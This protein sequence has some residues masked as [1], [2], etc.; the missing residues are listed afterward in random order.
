LT[1]PARAAELLALDPMMRVFVSGCYDIV[2]AGHIQF[3]REARALGDHLTVCFASSEVLWLH[4][5]RRSSLPDD[6]KRA[7][8]AALDPVDEVVIGEGLDEGIDFRD[9]FLRLRPDLLAVTED[10]K[11]APLKREL[12]AQVGARY[13]VLPKT[14]PQ[15]SPVS[16]TQIVKFIRAPEVAPL[17]VDFAGGWLDVPR[18]AR[19]GA[20]VVNCA[21]SPTVSLRAWPYER[22]AGLGGSGAWALLNGRDGVAS[23]L[24]LGVGWQDP[25]IIA[26][27]GLCVWRSGPRPELE[28]K[29]NGEFLRGRLALFWTGHDHDTPD[30][31]NRPR[32]FDAIERAGKIARDA[33]WHSDLAQLAAAVRASYAMQLGEGMHALPAEV[34]GALACK[35]AGGGFGG[36]AVFLFAE[37]D[38]RDAACARKNFRPIEPF[39]AAR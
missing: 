23:E 38:Q 9:H 6:H 37:K 19:A 18:F 27:T 36:Y 3:F 29:H 24:D 2:H 4:K 17:R 15:F 8:I 12:C 39:I 35:Y 1:P 33:V 30:L 21:I 14:P 11:Y 32:D 28:L 13:V 7:V 34:P 5:Q 16:T 31:A 20:Y 26:E 25:A 22:N 10:D